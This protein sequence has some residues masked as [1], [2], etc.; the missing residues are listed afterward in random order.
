M[1]DLPSATCSKTGQ[2]IFGSRQ[3]AS[4]Q[5][6]SRQ[7]EWEHPS[8]QSTSVENKAYDRLPSV[9]N[10]ARSRKLQDGTT[11]H[12]DFEAST[13]EFTLHGKF[14]SVL[15]KYQCQMLGWLWH[16]HIKEGALNDKLVWPQAVY[17]WFWLQALIECWFFSRTIW[18][19]PVYRLASA[20]QTAC[21]PSFKENCAPSGV[22]SS[23]LC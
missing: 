8:S 10:M 17:S 19:K 7:A 5:L 1:T 22:H 9:W 14:I 13:P 6:K 15:H 16:C 11:T 12:N 18:Q 4:R 3:L 20:E 23:A 2:R 21:M